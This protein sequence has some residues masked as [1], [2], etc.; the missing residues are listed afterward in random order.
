MAMKNEENSAN[1]IPCSVTLTE[2]KLYICHDEQDNALIRQLDSIKLEYVTQLFIDSQC[3]Y[4]CV[5][6]SVIE[7]LFCFSCPSRLKFLFFFFKSIEHRNQDSKSWI[8]YFLFTKEM[9]QFVKI[10]QNTLSNIYQVIYYL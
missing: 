7:F 2:Q 1:T 10:L 4:Y 5:L 9:I 3:P 8:F 6:V